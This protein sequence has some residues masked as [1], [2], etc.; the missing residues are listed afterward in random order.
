[1]AARALEGSLISL[2]ALVGTEVIDPLDRSVGRV[3]DV[4]VRWTRR[5]SYPAM[6]ALV[7]CIG[8]R[9]VLIGARWVEVTAPGSA[10]LRETKAYASQVERHP[11]D[12]ALAHDV[13]D[14]QVVD[15]SGVQIVRPADIYLA[16]V[17]GRI[18]AVGVEVGIRALLR[19]LGPK[20]LRGRLRPAH[21]IDWSSIS[22]FAPARA[23]GE[24]H[25]GRRGDLAGH[26]GSG[27]QLSS[28]SGEVRR[29]HASEVEAAL[30][31]V[32]VD[33]TAGPR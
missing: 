24:R 19:R 33:P 29:L 5:G 6:T 28:S 7:V 13:L 1:M 32:Q 4:V 22:A 15:S 31:E 23:D 20:V 27:L 26:A 9:D 2:A 30:R 10:R 14:R 18:E 17:N 3:R 12:V 25:R 21:V 16:A 8:R 11:A